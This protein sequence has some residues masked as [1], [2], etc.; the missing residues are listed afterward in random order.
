MKKQKI[1]I[2]IS[3]TFDGNSLRGIGYFTSRLVESIKT[4]LK[5]N[6]EFKNYQV[7]FLT[8]IDQN[9]SGYDLIHYPFFDPFKLTLPSK[10]NIPT[11]V[12]VYDLIPRQFKQFFPVGIKGEL[13]WQIQKA[14]LRH[15]DYLITCS[16]Y[17][18]HIISDLTGYPADRIYV[19]YAAADD[20]F[21]PIKNQTKLNSVSQKYH[22][23]DKF[24]LYLGDINWNKNIPSLV[25][26]CQKLKYPLV[27]VGS[28]AT[29]KDIPVHPWTQDLRWLQ[30]QAK[31]S[32]LIQLTG[33]VP[34]EDL[35]A[36]F[37]LAT[38][39]CQPSFAEGFGVPVVQAMQSGC[40]VAYS[41]ETSLPEVMDFNG[42]FFD[43]YSTSEI[44]TALS[45]LWNDPKL[46]NHYQKSGLKRARF[47]DWKLTAIQ[48]LSVYQLALL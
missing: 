18:K 39:Y 15:S 37:N 8:R 13:S 20:N 14:R 24:V 31:K 2:D 3:P 36:I 16:H 47:F 32:Q 10:K 38:I 17:S 28:A 40:T 21:R 1:A 30:S 33:F 19:T 48:T 41:T 35:P 45:K 46:R 11:I 22:L 6:P 4:E 5:T 34:D 27:I 29:E 42:E 12:T 44:Q 23:P 7:D 26:A 9:Q 43:P 25:K